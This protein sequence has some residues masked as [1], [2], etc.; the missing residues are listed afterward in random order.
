MDNP[1]MLLRIK[2]IISRLMNYSKLNCYE[3]QFN[4]G[5]N[6]AATSLHS[7]KV[8]RDGNIIY[9]PTHMLKSEDQIWVDVYAFSLDGS[10]R[11]ERRKPK[12]RG[13][14]ILGIATGSRP[15]AG[16]RESSSLSLG[17]K[18]GIIMRD[19]NRIPKVLKEIEKIWA[20]NPDLRL[21]Q[22]LINATMN[23]AGEMI[24]F[25]YMEDGNLI[26]KLNGLYDK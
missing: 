2:E 9:L 11:I 19:P 3:I 1:V 24:D 4:N 25:Y 13:R 20:Q 6:L 18:K 21:G 5:Y 8:F 12:S 17:T 16:R 23:E 15:Q 14:R 22:L 7:F 26:K 10:Y